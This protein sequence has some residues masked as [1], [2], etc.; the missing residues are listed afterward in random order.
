[1]GGLSTATQNL[2]GATKNAANASK[3][4]ASSASALAAAQRKATQSAIDEFNAESTLAGG[5]LAVQSAAS[6][7]AGD[8]KKLNTLRAQGKTG[9]AAYSTAV[10]Q[11]INDEIALTGAVDK[12]QSSVGGAAGA[13]SAVNSALATYGHALGLTT[14]QINALISS[15]DAEIAKADALAASI[16]SLPSSKVVNI[17]VA[18]HQ[19]GSPGP[20]PPGKPLP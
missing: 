9:T 6:T 20:V 1:M 10:L 17:T 5:F 11:A 8:Q 3:T 13:T 19:Q 12:Y 15:T 18:Y 4:A 7:V 2:S 14:G 16:N